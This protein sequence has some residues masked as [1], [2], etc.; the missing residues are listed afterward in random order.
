[1]PFCP[2]AAFSQCG[3]HVCVPRE[4]FIINGLSGPLRDRNP[5][6]RAGLHAL[7][8]FLPISVPKVPG[9]FISDPRQG[10]KCNQAV[11]TYDRSVGDFPVSYACGCSGRCHSEIHDGTCCGQVANVGRIRAGVE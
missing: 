3:I 8:E 1:M 2:G 10:L 6:L 9:D 11:V 7:G 5:F 4:K